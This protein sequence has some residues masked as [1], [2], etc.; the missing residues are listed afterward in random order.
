MRKNIIDRLPFDF[1]EKKYD[2]LNYLDGKETVDEMLNLVSLMPN[3]FYKIPEIF[4]RDVNI[5]SIVIDGNLTAFQV[6][7]EVV[8]L[9]IKRI[10][11]D[12]L[13]FYCKSDLSDR[14]RDDF[15]VFLINKIALISRLDVNQ[16]RGNHNTMNENEKLI[17]CDIDL[18][19][20]VGVNYSADYFFKFLKALHKFGDISLHG[21]N[22]GRLIRFDSSKF[23]LNLDMLNEVDLES[24]RNIIDDKIF[25]LIKE[26]NSDDFFKIFDKLC[27]I[28]NIPSSKK[29][30]FFMGNHIN[31]FDPIFIANAIGESSSNHHL[32][33]NFKYLS[34]NSKMKVVKL[35]EKDD[36]FIVF[37]ENTIGL[38][39]DYGEIDNFWNKYFAIKSKDKKWSIVKDYI[40]YRKKDSQMVLSGFKYRISGLNLHGDFYKLK[41]ILGDDYNPDRI[42]KIILNSSSDN[43]ASIISSLYLSDK[44]VWGGRFINFVKDEVLN[45]DG[46]YHMIWKLISKLPDDIVLSKEFGIYLKSN[47]KDNFKDSFCY[48]ISFKGFYEYKI[49][50]NPYFNDIE[51]L[52]CI[53]N[54]MSR[55][56]QS[57]IYETEMIYN[58]EVF[59]KN[60]ILFAVNNGIKINLNTFD[61][62]IFDDDIV[63]ALF[64]SKKIKDIGFW[65]KKLI[66]NKIHND[67]K[68]KGLLLLIYEKIFKYQRYDL[69]HCITSEVLEDK[70]FALVL[71]SNENFI[72]SG[73]VI[74]NG[75]LRVMNV[76]GFLDKLSDYKF[77]EDFFLFILEQLMNFS[78]VIF[79]VNLKNKDAEIYI[80]DELEA[81]KY[82][83]MINLQLVNKNYVI[84]FFSNQ[85]V[86][87]VGSYF[88]ECLKVD[89]LRQILDKYIDDFGS[90]NKLM[91]LLSILMPENKQLKQKSSMYIDNLVSDFDVGGSDV[92]RRL[93][94]FQVLSRRAVNEM[95]DANVLKE[96]H[97]PKIIK[98]LPE[99]KTVL[100][101]EYIKN[102]F[103]KKDE[104]YM[105]GKVFNMINNDCF[106]FIND[107]DSLQLL[108]DVEFF[109][110]SFCELMN[111]DMNEKK[112]K[113][114][115]NA[116]QVKFCDF[117]KL[118]F[119]IRDDVRLLAMIEDSIDVNVKDGFLGVCSN[120]VKKKLMDYSVD[121][122]KGYVEVLDAKIEADEMVESVKSD[123]SVL[124]KSG[125]LVKVR[126][127]M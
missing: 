63:E 109:N 33:E 104:L 70:R 21:T 51:L 10:L 64:N 65:V 7:S 13:N 73:T 78:R 26:K 61:L 75:D 72:P 83:N 126:S 4:K 50:Q 22:E 120:S 110:I 79:S 92:F 99:F 46:D 60:Y 8:Q 5:A 96:T 45:Y 86:D 44:K 90:N 58:R 103:G 117:S 1:N 34:I 16:L 52:K 27:A 38:M 14:Q 31:E 82:L 125:D 127:R 28:K 2:I 20:F 118:P 54:Y 93:L 48:M 3:I 124:L 87:G 101:I 53:K 76:L 25:Y 11:F 111:K 19:N 56:A 108:I 114:I 105:M 17:T 94:M 15:S 100:P 47:F 67:E 42:F 29:I 88:K 85:Y 77:D 95:I 84:K 115:Q 112:I 121:N 71:K 68:Y 122:F 39:E 81:L 66:E 97:L 40:E 59:N 113:Y 123:K 49:F 9:E 55:H 23:S 80:R 107:S 116:V 32:I 43:K 35:V 18:L 89:G 36:N 24:Y 12:I 74:S 69:I 102:F 6:K 91:L 30:N 98:A 62:D 106:N 37:F 41:L 119:W 57:Y